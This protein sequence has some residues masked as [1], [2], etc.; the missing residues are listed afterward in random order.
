[1]KNICEFDVE[2]IPSTTFPVTTGSQ[3]QIV[4]IGSDAE[5]DAG[6]DLFGVAQDVDL[7]NADAQDYA[8]VF[9]NSFNNAYYLKNNN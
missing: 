5:T 8:R 3:W 2:V 1:M 6:N 9:A 4:G 7:N